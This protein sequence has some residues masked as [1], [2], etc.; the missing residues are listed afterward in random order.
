MANIDK[1][2]QQSIVPQVVANARPA[3]ELMSAL[4]AQKDIDSACK[5]AGLPRPGRKPVHLLR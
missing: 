1:T 5:S 2:W 3:A 4:K